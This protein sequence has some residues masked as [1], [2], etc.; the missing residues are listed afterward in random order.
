MLCG[1][2]LVNRD[3]MRRVRTWFPKIQKNNDN[4]LMFI[5]QRHTA[6]ERDTSFEIF[7]IETLDEMHFLL[8]IP[9]L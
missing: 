4:L 6:S 7:K 1:K 9:F 5:D 3:T 8:I 2:V